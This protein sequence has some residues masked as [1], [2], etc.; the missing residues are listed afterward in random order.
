MFENDSSQKENK[1]LVR[2]LI[3]KL[4]LLARNS[5]IVL[6]VISLISLSIRLYYFP[7]G[8]PITHD[9]DYYFSYALDTVILGHFPDNYTFPNNGWP[10]F[11]SIFFSFF[12]SENLL[13]Y[14]NLQRYLSISISL[15]T[16]I[17]VYLLCSRFFK[18]TYALV[19]AAIFAFEPRII[20]NSLL[21][22]SEPLYILLG[23]LALYLFLSKD[24]RAVFASFVFAA[25]LALVR[26]EGLLLILPFSIM[27]FI[28]FRK[29]K[30]VIPKYFSTM[31]VFVL[32]LLPMTLVR[33]DTIGSDGLVSNIVQGP[34]HYVH[35]GMVHSED[36]QSKI[37]GIVFTGM[38]NFVKFFG[39]IMIPI[40]IFFV[41]L[42]AFMIFK[43]RDY[44]K[45]TIII[46]TITFLIPAFY[47]YSR[48]IQ[49]TKYFLPIFPI[50]CILSIFTIQKLEKQFAK[51][52][53]L[54]IILLIGII[55]SSLIFL[56]YKAINYE[57][58]RDLLGITY[59]V[60]DITGRIMND[61]GSGMKYLDSV[62][63]AKSDEFPILSSKL[64]TFTVFTKYDFNSIDEYIQYGKEDG[65]TYL[66]VDGNDVKL[67]I[68]NDVF[69]NENNYPYLV[70]VYDSLEHGYK[71]HIKIF[72][73][74]YQLFEKLHTG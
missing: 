9:G 21:G 73:I 28:R 8:L 17:P 51:S 56:Q 15:L 29:E 66:V 13:D 58:E 31:A 74:D 53:I 63:Y 64:P 34:R 54:M 25:V 12:N 71:Y 4:N 59:D 24:F 6:A 20:Q 32:V 57:H 38:F 68:L 27:F 7:Y 62:R 50:F 37:I 60:Y 69:F 67:P 33:I 19:G 47:A 55:L 70:R 16:V 43:K 48:D 26:Y 42:G 5:I 35:M 3:N 52:N 36:G 46:T 41:P 18:K 49:D 14:M 1:S 44:K 22:I 61:Y 30:L 65:L 11:L 39:W 40:F 2:S 72:K 45:T 10:A 23:T